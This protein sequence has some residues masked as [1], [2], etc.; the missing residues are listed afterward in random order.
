MMLPVLVSL[1][2]ASASIDVTLASKAESARLKCRHRGAPSRAFTA[3]KLLPSIAATAS[4]KV[5][6]PAQ[7]D[8][9]V[10]GRP[11]RRAVVF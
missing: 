2:A 1:L 10:A 3:L 6:S 5:H 9:P 8:E 11:D 7:I 4:L